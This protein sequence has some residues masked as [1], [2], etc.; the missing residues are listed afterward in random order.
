MQDWVFLYTITEQ[1]Y[2]DFNEHHLRK[3]PAGKKVVLKLR[4]MAAFIPILTLP[5]VFLL[6]TYAVV[7]VIQIA[8]IVAFSL[9]WY[10]TS[11]RRMLNATKRALKKQKPEDRLYSSQGQLV[12]DFENGIIIDTGEKAE[13]RVLF[14]N[15]IMCYETQYM[16]IFYFGTNR[17]IMLPYRLFNCAEDL[18]EFKSIIHSI[19]PCEYSQH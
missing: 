3:T 13:V 5:L 19:F 8:V 4:L 9:I 6:D 1:E 18:Y 14:N 10:F 15:I 11:I 12:F 7:K 17:A 2:L 16:F